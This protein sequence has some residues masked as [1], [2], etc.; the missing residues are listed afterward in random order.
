MFNGV[1]MLPIK[2]IA[3][4]TGHPLDVTGNNLLTI[5]RPAVIKMSTA[6]EDIQSVSREGERL[7]IK[8]KSGET[9]SIDGFFDVVDGVKSDL[10]F[11]DP[12]TGEL[13]IADYSVPWTGVSLVPLESIDSLLAVAEVESTGWLAP[14]LGLAA[15]GGAVA[16]A[17]HHGGGG[18]GGGSS[19]DAASADQGLTTP[20]TPSVLFN[21]MHGL[22]GKADAGATISLTLADG[23]VVTTV[24]DD[25]GLWHFNPNPLAD[26]EQ[27]TLQASLN[28]VQSA[29]IGS[30]VADVT[31]PA[32]PVVTQNNQDVL[33]GTAEPGSTIT[34]SL[35]DG[36][37][38]IATVGADGQWSVTPNPLTPGVSGSIVVT[39]AAGN[40]SASVDTGIINSTQPLPPTVDQNNADGLS[41][42]GEPG[43]TVVVELPDGSTVTTIIDADGNWEIVPNPVPEGEQGSVTVI[44]PEGNPS[45]AVNTGTSDQT[46]PAAPT[47]DQNNAN[48]ISGTGEPGSTVVVELPDGSTVTTVIDADGNWEIVPNPVPE[49]EQGSVTVTDPAGNTS[50]AVNTGTSDQ[51]PPAAPTIDQNNANGIS[52]TGEPGSTVVVELPD[53]STVTTVIDADGNWEIVPNPVPEGEQGSV[54]VIDPAGNTSEAVNTGSSEKAPLPAPADQDPPAAPTIDQNNANGISGT[55]E[56]GST[57]VVELPDGSTVTTI[58]DADG[59]WEI[60]PNPVPEGEQGSVTVIDPAGNTSEAVNTGT[61]DQTPPAAPTIDQNNA[62]GISGT[63]EPGSTVVVELPD[64]STVTTIIDADGNWEIVPNPVPEG[65]Q[66][67]ITVIDPAGNTSEAVS[68]GTSD[69]TPPA[70]PTIDQ[71]NANGISGTGEPGSTVVVE[72]PDGST[73]SSATSAVDK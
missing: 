12:N 23:S 71:N 63:G 40:S 24:A 50:E 31:A 55:G 17:S 32:E 26:G 67:S 33:A 70:A 18:G 2:I 72:L 5:N 22:T 8:L 56:P 27:G 65:E 45:E 48:G 14:L 62:N 47:I 20:S 51:T 68:T 16:I 60:V 36:S 21:N 6:A 34:V 35:A 42:T 37:T 29:A 52:G 73:Y 1:V 59:N 54:T 11:E 10:V 57:V 28:G 44:D 69:Q 66:G 39:D 3:K 61:S 58:I 4:D 49:G 19:S 43:S 41:G 9:L 38:V 30:G 25:T 46:P 15:V 13:L 64:G 7:V 53:G